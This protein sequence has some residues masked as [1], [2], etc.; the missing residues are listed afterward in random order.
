MYMSGR[1][2]QEKVSNLGSLHYSKDALAGTRIKAVAVC[3]WL[4]YSV[5]SSILHAN[6][7]FFKP[8]PSKEKA[9][10]AWIGKCNQGRTAGCS[11]K[12]QGEAEAKNR[13]FWPTSCRQKK[14]ATEL[15]RDLRYAVPTASSFK[16]DYWNPKCFTVSAMTLSCHQALHQLSGR[17]TK[18]GRC[19]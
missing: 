14:I 3:Y 5:H 4:G 17:S 19:R 15:G 16:T 2:G 6:V 12:D 7:D 9:N 11:G 8:Y 1:L 13:I 18:A 10:F